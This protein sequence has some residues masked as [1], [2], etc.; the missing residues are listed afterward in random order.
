MPTEDNISEEMPRIDPKKIDLDRVGVRPGIFVVHIENESI[1]RIDRIEDT[2]DDRKVYY[3][4]VGDNHES[5]LSLLTFLTRLRPLTQTEVFKLSF[6]LNH[7]EENNIPATQRN[8]KRIMAEKERED[9]EKENDLGELIMPDARYSWDNVIVS[10][11]VREQINVALHLINNRKQ[12]VETWG[13]DSFLENS[14]RCIVNFHGAPGTGKTLTARAIS[15][16]INKPVYKVRYSQIISKFI[17]D[18]GKHLD[19]VFKRAQEENAILFFDEADSMLSRRVSMDSGSCQAWANSVNQN[20]NILM[21]LIDSWDGIMIVATNLFGNYDEAI[22]RRIAR[23]IKFDLPNTF[24][25]HKIFERHIPIRSKVNSNVDLKSLAEMTAGFS[26]GDIMNVC[27]NAMENASMDDN[28]DNWN[29]NQN[30]LIDQINMIK[31]SKNEYKGR[32]LKKHIDFTKDKNLVD[33][34]LEE[35]EDSK[36]EN[37]LARVLSEHGINLDEVRQDFDNP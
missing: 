24:Q 32:T 20:R 18:T 30:H 8:I 37:S 22:L 4:R 12:F 15:A 11:D 34:V 5:W 2:E 28:P 31:D 17:G 36:E 33:K 6:A 3:K 7:L 25:R 21:Q 14:N 13:V 9:E 19:Q 27:I 29:L 26:G 23:H 10:E 35:M 1:H 16:H